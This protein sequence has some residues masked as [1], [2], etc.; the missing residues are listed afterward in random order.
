M[1]CYVLGFQEVDRARSAVVG[2]KGALLGELS[3]IDGIHVPAGFCVTTDAFQRIL[4]QAPSIDDRLDRLSRLQ[5]EDRE[6][7]RVLSAEI[8]RTLEE[9]AIPEELASAITATARPAWRAW[10]LCRSIQRDGGGPADGILRGSVRHLPE[11]HRPGIDP[12]ARQPVLG[13]A[14][15]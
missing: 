5:A 6:A 4:A 9:V 11:R 8:R 14:L 15:Q 13:L 7:I 3:R 1:D 2:G 12:A 10:R